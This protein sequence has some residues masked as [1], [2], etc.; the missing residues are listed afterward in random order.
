MK[1]F[2]FLPFTLAMVAVL[3]S[4]GDSAAYQAK[5]SHAAYYNNFHNTDYDKGRDYTFY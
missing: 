4:S 2:I 3:I 5:G 1:T